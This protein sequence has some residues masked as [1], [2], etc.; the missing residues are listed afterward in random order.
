MTRG[1]RTVLRAVAIDMAGGMIGLRAA[2]IGRLGGSRSPDL[3]GV[4]SA[5][6]G[7]REASALRRGRRPTGKAAVNGLKGRRRVQAASMLGRARLC[8]VRV[9]LRALR[10]VASARR[11]RRTGKAAVNG[12]KGRRRVQ[13]ASMLGRA[14]LC[15][16]RV[17]LRALRRVRSD[18]LAASARIVPRGA[19][20][21]AT[22][23]DLTAFPSRL[24]ESKWAMSMA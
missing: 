11:S 17:T 19:R 18:R 12:L 9:T 5:R 10:C 4:A 20:R 24:S 21:R 23:A 8:Q 16:V 13:A 15:Q 6:R 3:R 7:P 14:R 1:G 22:S 2:A